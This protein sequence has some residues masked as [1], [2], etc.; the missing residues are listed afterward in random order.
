MCW[1]LDN[2]FS[3]HA[4]T[5]SLL[6]GKYLFVGN[7]DFAVR[8]WNTES[9]SLH[10]VMH[11][12]TSNI[13]GLAYS[14][15]YD[16]LFS[17]GID[18]Q[19]ITWHNGQ[20]LFK[21]SYFKSGE[22]RF[23]APIY[24]ILFSNEFDI[25]VI[26]VDGEISTFELSPK[27]HEIIVD[28]ANK[29]P[30][31]KRQTLKICNER[32]YIILGA[33][34]RIFTASYDRCI[35][36]VNITD[37]TLYRVISKASTTVSS[38]IFDSTGQNLIIGDK[39]G[40][41]RTLSLDGLPLGV[42]ANGMESAVTDLF[43]DR[44]LKLLWYILA[45]GT[46]DLVDSLN[47]TNHLAE[48]FQIF[49]NLPRA[50]PDSTKFE[51]ILGNGPN[52]KI[53]AIVNRKYVY[54]WRW[55]ESDYSF[56]LDMPNKPI[57]KIIAFWHYDSLFSHLPQASRKNLNEGRSL[58][59]LNDS[60]KSKADISN[61]SNSISNSK[62]ISYQIPPTINTSL[63]NA[64]LNLFSAG[65]NAIS[66]KPASE[67]VYTHVEIFPEHDSPCTAIEYIY[68]ESSIIMG[69][70]DGFLV[71]VSLSS[72]K[73]YKE[74]QSFIP[75]KEIISI[76]SIAFTFDD[77][78]T[79]FVW[80]VHEGLQLLCKRERIHDMRLTC[81]AACERHNMFVSCDEA[82]FARTWTL[83]P[84]NQVK[85][86][87][88]LDYSAYGSIQCVCYSKGMDQWIF[89]SSDGVIRAYPVSKPTSPP[90]F[91]V[92]VLPCHVTA[93]A[94]GEDDEVYLGIDDR[95]IRI[96]SLKSGYQLA[97]YSGHTDL[98]T[99]ICIPD[100]GKRWLSLQWNGE[101]LF[102]MFRSYGKQ[103]S[104]AES[105]RSEYEQQKLPIIN[106]KR[107]IPKPSNET[108]KETPI[109]FYDK[110]RK[111]LL[112]KRREEEMQLMA[113]KMSPTWKM[114]STM[115]QHLNMA[116]NAYEIEK[117]KLSQIEVNKNPKISSSL[118]QSLAHPP[119]TVRPPHNTRSNY[120]LKTSQ[121][122]LLKRGVLG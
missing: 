82:G 117:K 45:D 63:V 70:K 49:K 96:M 101:I 43:Y 74:R 109:S 58:S 115:T 66:S 71:V 93:V 13:T 97:L 51:K 14:D 100:G 26:G 84:D 53:G 72:S 90:L 122:T 76:R 12:H 52:T 27:I 25:I 77:D 39:S 41:I 81:F 69:Y 11:G 9:S 120:S 110:A 29:C 50:G 8:Q 80:D 99:Q 18:G 28:N 64:G 102:W 44:S 55:S 78:M 59:I 73:S 36:S 56:K 31:I 118:S 106:K 114:L 105:S 38:M 30:F 42:L 4:V 6:H 111:T 95:T 19:L 34:R 40:A 17:V 1:V 65:T 62:L 2:A 37:I 22:R 16:L 75:V 107:E 46:I 94:A 47:G 21:Y 15:R 98:I 20:C 121:S 103:N 33:G 61:K 24:S 86:E 67:F 112:L 88:L 68:S 116:M 35:C 108:E 60:N 7:D 89:C 23:P 83:H 119:H 87:M 92:N 48:R 54:T 113:K 85:E 104:Y 79:M 57:P 10:R 3:I 91:N 32:I 5:A